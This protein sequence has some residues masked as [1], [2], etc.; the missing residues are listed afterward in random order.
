MPC[1]VTRESRGSGATF[2]P[3]ACAGGSRS[4][5]GHGDLWVKRLQEGTQNMAKTGRGWRSY[6][7]VGRWA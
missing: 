5:A 4:W 1:G 3:I 6:S 7:E 2:G